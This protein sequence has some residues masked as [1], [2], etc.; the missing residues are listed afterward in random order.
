LANSANTIGFRL[1]LYGVCDLR[2]VLSAVKVEAQLVPLKARLERI[3]DFTRI[4][5]I[6]V[7]TSQL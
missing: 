6:S 2:I 7:A 1:L 4:F 5:I 3:Q